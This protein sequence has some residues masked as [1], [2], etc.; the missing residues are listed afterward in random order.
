VG[1]SVARNQIQC[2]ENASSALLRSLC[3][4]GVEN[5][6]SF[7]TEAEEFSEKPWDHYWG[8]EGRFRTSVPFLGRHL[9]FNPSRQVG[10]NQIKAI[11]VLKFRQENKIAKC[12]EPQ[13]P[14]S[15]FG[16][17]IDS[18]ILAPRSHTASLTPY[19]S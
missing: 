2:S 15:L 9:E 11:S 14:A 13:N 10:R 4:L 3:F 6:G 8:A 1:T 18:T 12:S 19:L 17:C 5:S 7:L 16:L